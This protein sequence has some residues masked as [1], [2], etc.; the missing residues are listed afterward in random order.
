MLTEVNYVDGG[1][2]D[3]YAVTEWSAQ[4]AYNVLPTMTAEGT[5]KAIWLIVNANTGLTRILTNVNPVTHEVNNSKIYSADSTNASTATTWGEFSSGFSFV[6]NG[7]SV[8]TSGVIVGVPYRYT[9][10]YTY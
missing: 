6:V 8:T 1:G 5:P 10:V 2:G 9:F 7:T 4:T 3:R